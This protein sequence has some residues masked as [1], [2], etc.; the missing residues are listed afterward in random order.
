MHDFQGQSQTV[1]HVMLCLSVFSSKQCTIKQL[2]D[3]CFVI[4]RIINP[5]LDLG[6]GQGICGNLISVTVNN[7]SP[8]QDY[9]HPNDQTQPISE[10]LKKKFLSKIYN[11]VKSQLSDDLFR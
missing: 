2:L 6:V 9:V 4:S 11:A 10:M 5:W 1:F 8:I 7:N 3:T